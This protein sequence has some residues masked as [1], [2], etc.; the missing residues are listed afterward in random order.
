[1]S[2][3]SLCAW[4]L[5]RVLEAGIMKRLAVGETGRLSRL[6]FLS[7]VHSILGSGG[8]WLGRGYLI[9]GNRSTR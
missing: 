9:G 3:T 4:H 2:L 6:L 1:M 7:Q 5:T 8:L